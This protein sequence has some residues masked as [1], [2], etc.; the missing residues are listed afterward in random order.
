[1]T[2]RVRAD[3]RKRR[4]A[5]LVEVPETMKWDVGDSAEDLTALIRKVGRVLDSSEVSLVTHYG[6]MERRDCLHPHGF[7]LREPWRGSTALVPTCEDCGVQMLT[8]DLKE[9]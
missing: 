4:E 7:R 3:V 5:A 2:N 9:A 6:Y 1:M 8:D